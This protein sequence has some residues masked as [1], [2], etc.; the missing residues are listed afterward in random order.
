MPIENNAVLI[1][2]NQN[3]IPLT[4]TLTNISD[5]SSAVIYDNDIKVRSWLEHQIELGN[6]F[7]SF[8]R[9][10]IAGTETIHF[11][12]NP[13]LCN[14]E[15]YLQI[16]NFTSIDTTVHIDLFTASDWTG[17]TNVPLYN[18]NGNAS[19]TTSVTTLTQGVTPSPLGVEFGNLTIYSTTSPFTSSSE[20]GTNPFLKI[21]T[22]TKD[23]I[24]FINQ[25]ANATTI[26]YQLY[27]VE[28][29]S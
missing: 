3:E 16:P 29:T 1:D 12:L 9:F 19:K 15:L 14:C 28:K 25:T 18:A 6:V 10:A 27:I 23:I 5:N 24:R 17:G 4:E 11:G 7:F 22:S 20:A 26:T 13:T 2:T 8:L 21:N